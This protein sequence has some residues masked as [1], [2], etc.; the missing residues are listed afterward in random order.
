MAGS[1]FFEALRRAWRQGLYWGIGL[2]LLGFYVTAIIQDM[3]MLQQYQQMIESLPPVMLQLFGSEDLTSF[4]TPEGF[5]AFGFY[6]YGL[7]M[8]GIFAVLGGLNITA[9]DE[10]SGALDLLLAL[11]VPR[12][13]VVL[14]RFAA[15]AVVSA[16]IAFVSYL[17][18]WLGAQMSGIEFNLVRL[19]EGNINFIPGLLL[20]IAFTAFAGALLPRKSSATVLAASFIVASYFVNFLGAAASDSFLANVKGLSFFN[21]YA[22]EAVMRDGLNFGNMAILLIASALLV[23]AAVWLFERRDVGG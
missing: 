6:T 20:M 8:L 13:R 21:Y 10:D 17:G 23:G 14:E 19:V 9:N 7:L 12:W 1:I 4:T 2:G 22:S 18:V 16:I 3:D 15:Y 5:V 11:P